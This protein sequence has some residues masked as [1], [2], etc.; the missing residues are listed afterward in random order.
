M[1]A[2]DI[3]HFPGHV[4]VDHVFAGLALYTI[5]IFQLC[6]G[7]RLIRPDYYYR[8]SYNRNRGRKLA[9]FM[10]M[11]GFLYAIIHLSQMGVALGFSKP[12]LVSLH[13]LYAFLGCGFFLAGSLK[14]AFS[15]NSVMTTCLDPS[16]LIGLG[17]M[18]LA[19]FFH[20]GF[21]TE[22]S[23]E[24][25]KLQIAIQTGNWLYQSVAICLFL[26]GLTDL[27]EQ[28]QKKKWL[29]VQGCLWLTTAILFVISSEEIVKLLTLG[30]GAL[31][32]M[33]PVVICCMYF[34]GIHIMILAWIS[35]WKNRDM[36]EE[37]VCSSIEDYDEQNDETDLDVHM[38]VYSQQQN[39]IP[40]TSVRNRKIPPRPTFT[41]GDNNNNNNNNNNSGNSSSSDSIIISE[42]YL[43][44]AVEN[45]IS[46]TTT[47]VTNNDPESNHSNSSSESEIGHNSEN[48]NSD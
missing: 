42:D 28:I 46:G 15:R 2:I 18:G 3:L 10:M 48:D 32:G 16:I 11:A 14:C 23:A 21:S 31:F 43:T 8:N 12:Q 6:R 47:A 35:S 29:V 40:M 19:L 26:I 34:V 9:I 13:N 4:V 20:P 25:S 44:N 22:D 37:V 1:T 39:H 41:L 24:D 17:G 30:S 45:S 36:L 38:P 33:G 5:G 7:M 27:L